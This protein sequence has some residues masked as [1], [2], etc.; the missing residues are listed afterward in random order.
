MKKAKCP[1]VPVAIEGAYDAW[2][3][4]RGHPKVLGCRVYVKYGDPIDSVELLKDG[5]DAGLELLRNRIEALRL[6]LRAQLRQ[7]SNGR[8]PATGPGDE[9]LKP[10]RGK[11]ANGSEATA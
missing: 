10:Q 9:P 7:Q 5:P 3:I 4:H 2:P 11:P 1:V 8:F 6:E